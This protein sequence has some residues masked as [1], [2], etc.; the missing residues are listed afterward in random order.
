MPLT[1]RRTRG[2]ET[3]HFRADCAHWPRSEFDEERRT[4]TTGRC[5]VECT[6]WPQPTLTEFGMPRPLRYAPIR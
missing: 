5:C 3:W 2:S 4:P 1:Y 6:Y